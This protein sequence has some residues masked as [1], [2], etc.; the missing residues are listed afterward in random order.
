[1]TDLTAMALRL[2]EA[3]KECPCFKDPDGPNRQCDMCGGLTSPH[4][5]SCETPDCK[6]TGEVYVLGPEVRVE[7]PGIFAIG[8]MRCPTLYWP[9]YSEEVLD[10]DPCDGRGWL[11][12]DPEKLGRWMVAIRRNRYLIQLRINLFPPEWQCKIG[13]PP[14]WWDF[15]ADTPE[16][17]FFTAA[18]KALKVEVEV[19]SGE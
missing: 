2:A 19:A 6:G 8:N 17:A 4:A 16:E 18:T 3:K 1:M 12:L 11:P 14:N 5:P 10:A 15:K 13:H 7:C 9:D